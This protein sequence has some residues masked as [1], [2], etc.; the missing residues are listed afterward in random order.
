MTVASE[1][2]GWSRPFAR[3]FR[4]AVRNTDM[5]HVHAIW[6]FPS[7][8]A[9]REAYRVGV[10]Y[11]VA[12][13]GSL[14]DWALGRSRL[15]KALYASVAEKPYFDRARAM[16]ALT[17]IEAAQCR[18]FGIKAPVTI[19]PN[20]VDLATVDRQPPRPD[21]RMELSL[22]VDSVLFLFLGRL[23]PKKGLD[24]LIPAFGKLA[25]IR[26]D[27]FLLV[28]GDDAGSRYC[29]DVERLALTHGVAPR[30][31][32]LGEVCGDRKFAILRGTDVFVLTS[33][34]EGLP[35][36]VLE[37]MACRCPVV[38]T[39]NCN[40]TEVK[41]REAGWLVEANIDSVFSGLSEAA[42]SPGERR[43][44]GDNGRSLVEENFTW[45]RIALESIRL[46]RSHQCRTN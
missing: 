15:L 38:I 43:R 10:P 21:L 3:A 19:L 25:A 8:C 17:A 31:R 45:D 4:S 18:R 30:T 35:V 24:L 2:V 34:S 6:N 13:Q 42:A 23:F 29:A 46:Y 32:F 1:H 40:L 5:V 20:G 16:Q 41:D 22:P 33:H 26:A 36:A 44:R 37:A 7:W 12:P 14:E 11:V 9:M 28:A 39:R 27:V